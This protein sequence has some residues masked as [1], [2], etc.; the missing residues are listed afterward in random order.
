MDDVT[1]MKKGE[2]KS[3]ATKTLDAVSDAAVAQLGP[4]LR[5][6]FRGLNDIQ[7]GFVGIMFDLSLDFAKY[8]LNSLTD[9]SDQ[10]RNRGRDWNNGRIIAEPLEHTG[11]PTEARVPANGSTGMDDRFVKNPAA[12]YSI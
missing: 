2:F 6:T 9:E 4:R 10:D 7:R 8:T 5:S 12:S 11:S 3:S 1:S